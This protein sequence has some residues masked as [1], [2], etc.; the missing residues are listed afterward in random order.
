[1]KNK[2]IIIIGLVSVLGFA[3]LLWGLNFLKGRDIFKK[4]AK[5]YAVYR[6]VNGL[7]ETN[8]I[9]MNG[10]KIGQVKKISFMNDLQ[11]H[12]VV[13][14]VVDNN[15]SIPKNSI[16]RIFSS[17]LMGSKAIAVVPGNSV[18]MAVSG[19][20]LV[21]D[22]QTTFQE[23][24]NNQVIPL[25]IKAENLISSLDSLVTTVQKILNKNTRDNLEKSFE[26]I[27][28]TIKN[29]ESISFKVDTLMVTEQFRIKRILLNVESITNN[30]KN[31]NEQIK[32]I[33]VNFSAVSD[34][35]AKADFA[36]TLRS[37]DKSLAQ[38]SEIVTKINKGE[39]SLG[40]LINNDTVY[41]NLNQA[42]KHLD[43]L[44]TDIKSNPHRY[45]RVS[46]FGRNPKKDSYVNPSENKGKNK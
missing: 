1:M 3:L 37:A 28:Y 26:S 22:I 42:T 31:N 7:S 15:V 39:G 30:L 6:Q 8:P 5:Y 17:D 41:N 27:K 29:I 11:R 2:R 21:T 36:N 34:S 33:I 46:V 20:T 12:L 44:I 19:D 35:L 43:E 16:A 14:L 24:I 23:E 10:Y 45:V 13:E 9:L 40:A 38:V 18:N 4:R 32:N 25:K